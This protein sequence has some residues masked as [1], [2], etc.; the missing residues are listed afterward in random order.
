VS[1]QVYRVLADRAQ[2]RHP[3][4]LPLPTTVVALASGEAIA[5]FDG[6]PLLKYDSLE[7]LLSAFELTPDEIEATGAERGSV[8]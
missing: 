3:R 6:E 2:S 7:T 1:K 4:R 5:C 8:G